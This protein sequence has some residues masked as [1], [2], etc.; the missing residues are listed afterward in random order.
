MHATD[1]AFIRFNSNITYN[2]YIQYSSVTGST[3]QTHYLNGTTYSPAVGN[4]LYK[5]GGS[6]YRTS[7]T[8]SS[9]SSASYTSGIYFTDMIAVP[10]AIAGGGDSGGIAYRLVSGNSAGILGIVKAVNND[11]TF[12][13]KA[14]N[15]NSILGLTSY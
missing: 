8:I 10:G 11:V 3:A 2:Q 14:S 13:I 5:S 12:F 4:T 15:I 7:E 9:V 1:A 6:T